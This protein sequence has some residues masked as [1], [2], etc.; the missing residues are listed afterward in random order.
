[1]IPE[2]VEV[3]KTEG[4]TRVVACNHFELPPGQIEALNAEG[5]QYLWLKILDFCAA[6]IPKLIESSEFIESNPGATL[7]YCGLGRG[8][9]A[10]VIAA[11]EV[12]TGRKTADEAIDSS[13]METDDQKEAV[14]SVP[15]RQ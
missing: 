1:M 3:L 4:I 10:M 2:A 12:Y 15:K 7:V 6:P 9:T 8:R 5:I 13:T 14:R 11:W